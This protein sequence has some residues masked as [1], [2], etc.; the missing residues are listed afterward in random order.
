MSVGYQGWISRPNSAAQYRHLYLSGCLNLFL[1]DTSNLFKV[2]KSP[3]DFLL[4]LTSYIDIFNT[5]SISDATICPCVG[6]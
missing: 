3:K 2:H 1:L 5:Q 4:Y 6:N